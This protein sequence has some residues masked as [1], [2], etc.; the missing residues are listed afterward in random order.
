MEGTKSRKPEDTPFKQQRMTA[1]QPILTP[2][3]V[4]VIFLAIGITFVPVGVHLLD[5]SKEIYEKTVVY[6]GSNADVNSCKI[7][8]TNAGATC[9]IDFDI[10]KDV[11]APIY[12]YYRLE[13]FYQNHRRYVKSRSA[14]QLEG[15]DLSKAD[16]ETDCDPLYKN[17]SLLLNPCGLIANSLFNDVISL[18]PGAHGHKLDETG[19]SWISDREVKFNQVDGFKK[20]N[21]TGEDL[22]NYTCADAFGNNKHD[23]CKVYTDSEGSVWYYW[24]PDDAKVQYLYESYPMVVNPLEGVDNEH[25][26]VWM[27]TAGLPTFRK[28]YGQIH[29]NL[30]KG[31]KLTF[32]LQLNFE[33]NSFDGSKGIVL[34]TVGEFGG[35]NAFLGISY[36]VV[37]SV[38]LLLAVLFSIKHLVAPRTMGDGTNWN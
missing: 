2:M 10:D 4:I 32:D 23:D 20:A 8:E 12:V 31:D 13:N 6:D 1:W 27:R 25:F 38:C 5:E 11:T 37:G 36:I 30:K 24:Y 14:F 26:I 35:K 19:I 15:Q 21:V 33:V 9:S 34:S 28:L 17:G 18:R 7:T 16:V 22:S 29:S 3:K